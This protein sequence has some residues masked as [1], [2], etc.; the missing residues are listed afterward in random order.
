MMGYL[1]LTAAGFSNVQLRIAFNNQA[2]II[3]VDTENLEIK[4]F[5]REP[6]QANCFQSVRQIQDDGGKAPEIFLACRIR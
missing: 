3:F 5:F 2:F 6:A 1:N 4:T